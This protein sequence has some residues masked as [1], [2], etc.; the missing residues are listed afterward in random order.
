MVYGIWYI[1]YNIVGGI[2]PIVLTMNVS[3]LGNFWLCSLTMMMTVRNDLNAR[4][5]LLSVHIQIENREFRRL[6]EFSGVFIATS[7]WAHIASDAE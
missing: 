4:A 5:F 2:W 1:W 7:D 6:C 3:A